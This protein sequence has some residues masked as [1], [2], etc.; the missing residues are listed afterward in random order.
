MISTHRMIRFVLTLLLG[1]SFAACGG[2]DSSQ[3]ITSN[4]TLAVATTSLPDGIQSVAYSETLTATGGD[5]SYTWSVTV[6]SLPT[7][8]SLTTSTGEISGTPSAVGSQTFTVEVASGDG[9]TDTQ[10]LTITVNAPPPPP[11]PPPVGNAVNVDDFFFDPSALTVSVGTTVT[12]T[13]VG[14]S[15][16][17]VTF[18]D[19]VENSVTQSGGVHTRQF[20]QTGTFGYFCSVHGAGVMS[21]EIVVQ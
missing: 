7:G 19:G 21:G 13:W 12:W 3:P 14:A 20:D 11:P 15:S 10:Q 9:Q 17:S 2:D 5:G 16:H 6:G 1:A 8:L 18:D 4:P